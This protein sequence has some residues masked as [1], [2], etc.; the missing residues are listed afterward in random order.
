[1]HFRDAFIDAQTGNPIVSGRILLDM[2]GDRK[3]VLPAHD[4]ILLDFAP[5]GLACKAVTE[6]KKL[7]TGFYQTHTAEPHI[8]F[9]SLTVAEF[10]RIVPASENE[11][12]VRRNGGSLS[13]RWKTVFGVTEFDLSQSLSAEGL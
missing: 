6:V 11:G 8:L 9:T 10:G 7:Q 13:E 3:F 5:N 1:M 2:R 12:Q 4:Q